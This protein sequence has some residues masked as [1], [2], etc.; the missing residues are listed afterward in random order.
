MKRR[1]SRIKIAASTNGTATLTL[2]RSNAPSGRIRASVEI[3]SSRESR[4]G[5]ILDYEHGSP[6]NR[7][8]RKLRSFDRRT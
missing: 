8:E 4:R 7:A 6:V 5:S 3:Q 1:S 2:H